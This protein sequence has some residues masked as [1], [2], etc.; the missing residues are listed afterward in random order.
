MSLE[1]KLKWEP[2]TH[3]DRLDYYLLIVRS[4]IKY[5]QLIIWLKVLIFL[6][7]PIVII[8]MINYS[9]V[10]SKEDITINEMRDI[11]SRLLFSHRDCIIAKQIIYC[12]TVSSRGNTIKM[13]TIPCYS[14]H[15]ILI[16]SAIITFSMLYF[17]K[18]SPKLIKKNNRAAHV[19]SM[20]LLSFS[21]YFFNDK[22]KISFPKWSPSP[23]T[24]IYLIGWP[25]HKHVNRQY[26]DTQPR[27]SFKETPRMW[28]EWR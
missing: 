17:A 12:D 11:F 6:S 25:Y 18:L 15:L 28:V 13:R 7:T 4:Q 1:G 14:F 26:N 10:C 8:T 22:H 19:F 16:N 3:T 23:L 20:L 24:L 21:W 9:Y 27:C 2:M 5:L